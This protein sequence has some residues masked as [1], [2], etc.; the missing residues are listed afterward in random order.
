MSTL[1]ANRSRVAEDEWLGYHF[2][3]ITIEDSDD[4]QMTSPGREWKRIFYMANPCDDGAPTRKSV[5]T[6]LFVAD[7]SDIVEDAYAL[8]MDTGSLIGRRI[9]EAT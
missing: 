1:F 2:G 5:F 9:A 4:W 7:D 8:T 6:L 3:P